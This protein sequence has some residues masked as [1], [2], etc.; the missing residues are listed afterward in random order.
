M[1]WAIVA[2]ARTL[3]RPHASRLA[4]KACLLHVDD[5]VYL[6]ARLEPA[7]QGRDMARRRAAAVQVGVTKNPMVLPTRSL[8]SGYDASEA[9]SMHR[10][11]L[12]NQKRKRAGL[13]IPPRWHCPPPLPRAAC[14]MQIRG[15]GA[16]LTMPS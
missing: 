13:A 5:N 9:D 4:T 6:E 8:W 10:E 14:P 11:S 15:L 16:N 3:P 7:D 2:H 12:W 1:R